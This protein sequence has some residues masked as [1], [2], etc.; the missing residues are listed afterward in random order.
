MDWQQVIISGVVGVIAVGLISVMRRKQWIGRIS[1]I[2]IFIGI[3]AAWNFLGVNYLFSGKTFSEELRQAE[4]AMSQLP[5]YR[6]IKESDPVFYDKLQVKMVKL[7]REGK[8]EQQLIDIIQTD[9]SS[10]LISRLYYAPDDKV[11][12]QMRNTLKQIEKFQAYGADSCFK[13]LFPA[14]SGGVNPA[15]ILPLEIMQ[16]RMQAD[17]DLIAASYITPRAV[18]K[19]QEIEAAKQAIQPILQ[20]MQLKYGDDLQMVVRPEAANV[21]RKRACDIMQDFYQSILSLPQ[22][23]SAAV[24]RM[25]LSS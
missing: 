16:Q 4:T 12:A 23:Q 24:L 5:V 20:Q 13:F 10:F 15:K 3:I 6:T 9:I 25:V 19:T 7:K 21:D 1:G 8:S 17:N 22:A 2:A 11:V 18:D 14:V